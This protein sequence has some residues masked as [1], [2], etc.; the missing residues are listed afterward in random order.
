MYRTHW[1]VAFN[2][3]RGTI[4]IRRTCAEAIAPQSPLRARHCGGGSTTHDY[5]DQD[6]SGN[7]SGMSYFSPQGNDI[8]PSRSFV[9]PTLS[10]ETERRCKIRRQSTLAA[11][12][13]LHQ[14]KRRE[15][16][17]TYSSY[18]VGFRS[19]VET[20]CCLRGYHRNKETLVKNEIY[21]PRALVLFQVCGCLRSQIIHF[22]HLKHIA[23]S[24]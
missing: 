14:Y 9:L 13:F 2:S 23:D 16:G 12:A 15:E 17:S 7:I 18:L 21:N 8:M 11:A 3:T 4:E 6:F 20:S 22:I 24:V 5:L 10:S 19:T 1:Q